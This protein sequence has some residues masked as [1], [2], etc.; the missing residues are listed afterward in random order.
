[1][2]TTRHS[3]AQFGCAVFADN[4]RTFAYHQ[5]ACREGLYPD[6]CQVDLEDCSCELDT[7]SDMFT[8]PID[9]LAP[10]YDP[11][12][13]ASSEFLGA[14]IL[15]VSGVADSTVK[16]DP[17]DAFGDGTVLN[18]QRL[19]GRSLTFDIIL[20]STTCRGADFAVEWLRR[21][22]EADLCGCG[23]SPCDSCYGKELKLRRSCN[24]PVPCDTG[25]RH[26]MSVGV[27]DGI[28][29]TAATDKACACVVQRAS[30]QLQSESPFSYGCEDVGCNLNAVVDPSFVK[31]FDWAAECDE[32]CDAD[33]RAGRRK[34][35]RCQTDILCTDVTTEDP[36]PTSLSSIDPCYCEPLQRRIQACCID[37]VGA[38]GFDTALKMEVFSGLDPSNDFDANFFLDHGLRNMRISIFNN[39]DGLPCI[40][41][42]ASYDAWCA[43]RPKP[44][45]ELQIP[46]VPSNAVLTIDGR[47]NRVT[48]E[49]NGECRPFPYSIDSKKGRLFPLVTNCEPMMVTVEWDEANSQLKTG[50]G[51]MPSTATFTTYRRWRS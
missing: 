20:L 32:C 38:A 40:D 37:D 47:S 15:E 14:M 5:W 1:M 9:D 48:M 11:N 26:W 50:G 3:F 45:F 22:L 29:V 34:C 2:S 51:R 28:K 10:W 16:R 31:C 25:L 43:T 35:D 12:D 7:T 44:R 27:V 8:N 46:Y 6:G 17:S 33:V 36:I 23:P 4:A 39:P 41:D 49:C 21:V 13:P 18:R 24:D 30:F 42:E 19:A